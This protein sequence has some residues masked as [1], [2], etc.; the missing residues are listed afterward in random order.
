MIVGSP[1]QRRNEATSSVCAVKQEYVSS[2]EA[3]HL[4]ASTLHGSV[5]RRIVDRQQE[6]ITPNVKRIKQER[7]DEPALCENNE[8]L[9]LASELTDLQKIVNEVAD[10]L[11]ISPCE[12]IFSYE[13]NS[14]SEI[15]NG[16]QSAQDD[17]T[18]FEHR[19]TRLQQSTPNAEDVTKLPIHKRAEI[20]ASSIASR[21]G[22]LSV[23]PNAE[24]VQT[25]PN[26]PVLRTLQS[27]D[28]GGSDGFAYDHMFFPKLV[29]VHSISSQALQVTST[30][31][32]SH[33]KSHQTSGLPEPR[34]KHDQAINNSFFSVK[35]R[36][37]PITISNGNHVPNYATEISHTTT[38]YTGKAVS[39]VRPVQLLS[40]AL[41]SSSLHTRDLHIG[42]RSDPQDT[43][44]YYNVRDPQIN[45]KIV[46][47]KEQTVMS[48][49]ILN[50]VGGGGT[51]PPNTT[52]FVK[53]SPR[54]KELESATSLSASSLF[55]ASSRIR[56]VSFSLMY[57]NKPTSQSHSLQ[58]ETSQK[59]NS[60]TSFSKENYLYMQ[61]AVNIYRMNMSDSLRP[62]SQKQYDLLFT[63]TQEDGQSAMFVVMN[64]EVISVRRFDHKGES[65]LI[66]TDNNGKTKIVS[67]LPK[68]AQMIPLNSSARVASCPRISQVKSY[69]GNKN[70]PTS[71]SEQP[72]HTSYHKVNSQYSTGTPTTISPAQ[73]NFV[74]MYGVS[75]S[76]QSG[77]ASYQSVNS[78]YPSETPPTIPPVQNNFVHTYGV[79]S[80][81][82][83]GH[84]SYQN[85]NSQYPCATPTT[86][87]PAQNNFVQTYAVSSSEQSSHASYQN[88]RDSQYPN[89]TPVT[90]SPVQS[91][92]VQTFSAS[93]SITNTSLATPNRQQA[94]QG[95]PR[96][97]Q[98]QEN[99]TFLNA[100]DVYYD[101]QAVYGGMRMPHIFA[102]D[103]PVTGA[104]NVEIRQISS[105]VNGLRT[106]TFATGSPQRV[107]A[108]QRSVPPQTLSV[109][110][111][112]LVANASPHNSTAVR[113][114][115]HATLGTAHASLNSLSNQQL[116]LNQ[117]TTARYDWNIAMHDRSEQQYASTATQRIY[118]RDIAVGNGAQ[119]YLSKEAVN[120]NPYRRVYYNNRRNVSQANEIRI[121]EQEKIKNFI[122]DQLTPR[123]ESAP[124]TSNA[125]VSG[126]STTVKVRKASN[127]VKANTEDSRTVS[128]SRIHREK[129]CQP[130][131]Q[132]QE[133]LAETAL[134]TDSD[135][136]IA[137]RC[138][139]SEPV[140]PPRR[141]CQEE[142][143]VANQPCNAEKPGETDETVEI[144]NPLLKRDA[145]HSTT[146]HSEHNDKDQVRAKSTSEVE[147]RGD[148]EK[149][150]TDGVADMINP[151]LKQNLQP[152]TTD[153]IE[154]KDEDTPTNAKSTPEVVNSCD[155]VKTE[156]AED[157]TAIKPLPNQHSI[158]NI[159]S[160]PERKE[161]REES[162]KR[163]D[164]DRNYKVGLRAELKRKIRNIQERK[165][166][167]TELNKKYLCRLEAS[168]KK[169]LADVSGAVEVI[170]IDDE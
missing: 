137:S 31:V 72:W 112:G 22:N 53:N 151:T 8:Q 98:V 123:G 4:A 117:N 144:T 170:A 54:Y 76:E 39:R 95:I 65:Y 162:S 155:V 91:N 120:V 156:P 30:R 70:A 36:N 106:E 61:E 17:V 110:H 107:L 19:E 40:S 119:S 136:S 2:E 21:K 111:P 24:Q 127:G 138:S 88:A 50:S 64:D 14:S 124:S 25:Q 135:D 26:K 27:L 85:V 153:F 59:A 149:A 122:T 15:A 47:Q 96:E 159:T 133:P 89:E 5:K 6:V 103:V 33:Q 145:R 1:P 90:I 169:K 18:F 102:K 10:S 157:A 125:S 77:H 114:N 67:K 147:T 94:V 148:A 7:D 129:A 51:R 84:T 167:E 99:R 142:P 134:A 75:S 86:M 160:S 9:S 152:N 104:L 116:N 73:N 46:C 13:G 78:Q 154:N 100:N 143:K 79:S 74:H 55:P 109:T 161:S 34:E 118:N 16:T 11:E 44:G 97:M 82:Q 130:R 105:Q 80:S 146:N 126:K 164:A 43:S 38:N 52:V 150:E 12:D 115:A 58:N 163:I 140:L 71:A 69:G 83:S 168:L 35:D 108:S 62:G 141:T 131:L 121:M 139:Q 23:L 57:S 41:D 165:E 81:E 28:S 48:Q 92:F 20:M 37:T 66:H 132:R 93:T 32:N 60:S 158:P 166:Q 45:T 68:Q 3:C 56:P 113:M 128:A 49:P 42:S 101:N 63:F 87:S 29:G